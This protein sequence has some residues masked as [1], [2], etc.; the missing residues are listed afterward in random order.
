MKDMQDK[1][2]M[3]I[4]RKFEDTIRDEQD[5]YDNT[6]WSVPLFRARTGTLKLNW[7]RGHTDGHTIC[8]LCKMNLIE[9]IHHFLM[10]CTAII[11]TRKT[12]LGL[13]R[14]SI[15]W[16]QNNSR[17]SAFLVTKQKERYTGIGMIFRN[18]DN[19]EAKSYIKNIEEMKRRYS[20]KS[21]NLYTMCQ[22]SLYLSNSWTLRVPI[23]RLYPLQSTV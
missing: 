2:T 1:S 19:I 9:V 10:E 17:V 4:Y 15:I 12:I 6:A 5:L 13:Q 11:D 18:S 23:Q 22:C 20:R 8:D 14:P 21:Y 3:C 16:G 7:E